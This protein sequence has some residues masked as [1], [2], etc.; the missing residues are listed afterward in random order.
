MASQILCRR[1]RHEHGALPM[2]P[3]EALSAKG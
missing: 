3:Y 2:N 1:C